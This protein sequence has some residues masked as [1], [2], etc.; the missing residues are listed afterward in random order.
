MMYTCPCCCYNTLDETGHYY[1]CPICFWE[2]D[3]TQRKNIDYISGA[4][5]TS[6]RQARYNFLLI[7]ACRSDMTKSVRKLSKENTIDKDLK[8]SIIKDIGS[9]ALHNFYNDYL[10]ANTWVQRK[11][12]IPLDL[13]EELSEDET[14]IAENEFLITLDSTRDYWIFLGLSFLKS[15]RA[16]PTFYS[17]LE[18]EDNIKM[19][20]YLSYSIYR[21][22]EDQTMIN[23]V[24][25]EMSKL[26]E[27]YD[28]I[29][30]L[31]L[32]PDFQNEKTDKLLK[33]YTTHNHCL[34]AYNAKR[35]T[36]GL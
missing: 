26:K 28:I 4:N 10:F 34:V 35:I 23:I 6:L 14:I 8:L 24:L 13:L 5:N 15:H 19:R 33:Q 30:F 3:P 2:D 1:I 22:I 20:I 27:W 12:G 18:K 32:L 16:L 21:I 11:D 31:F 17:L 7:G 25:D 9:E 36:K 29:D